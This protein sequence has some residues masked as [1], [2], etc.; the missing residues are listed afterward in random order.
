[1]RFVTLL[2]IVFEMSS[3]LALGYEFASHSLSLHIQGIWDEQM[4]EEIIANEG[5]VQNLPRIPVSL[6][7]RFKT[8]WEISQKVLIDQSAGRNDKQ[9]S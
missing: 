7:Q 3:Y 6:R 2:L 9:L 5:S 4:K 1:M 8:V